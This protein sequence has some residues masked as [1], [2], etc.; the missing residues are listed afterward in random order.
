MPTEIFF[1]I[2]DNHYDTIEHQKIF[3]YSEVSGRT[4]EGPI[5]FSIAEVQSQMGTQVCAR[6]LFMNAC[7]G[8]DTTS[9]IH[10]FGKKQAFKWISESNVA[11][12]EALQF[13]REDLTPRAIEE[14]GEKLFKDLYKCPQNKSVSS[15]RYHLC[16]KSLS[17]SK[18]GFN[19]KVCLQHSQPLRF[20][21]GE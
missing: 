4:K 16:S 20:T 6:I 2:L 7:F 12:H 9:S 14:A 21:Q 17:T 5:F 15:M 1:Q 19:L 8:C 13:Y 18:T 10:G 3:C 11:A